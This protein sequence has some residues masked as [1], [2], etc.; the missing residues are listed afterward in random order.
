MISQRSVD[1][2]G[3]EERAHWENNMTSFHRT[4]LLDNH[5]LLCLI[6]EHS[7]YMIY[8]SLIYSSLLIN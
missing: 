2:I 7:R 5:I 6:I 1:T 4:R 3:K 8:Y